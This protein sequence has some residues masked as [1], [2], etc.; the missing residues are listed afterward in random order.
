[1]KQ[2]KLILLL[3]GIFVMVFFA[4]SCTTEES[5]ES[6]SVSKDSEWKQAL[7]KERREKDENFKK[8]PDSP[9]ARC[10]RL[11]VL[12]D[13]G[14]AFVLEKENDVALTKEKEPGVKFSIVFEGEQ[15]LWF[16]HAQGVTGTAGDKPVEPRTPL[17]SRVTFKLDRC[18]L[19]TYVMKDRLLFMVYD[20]LRPEFKEFSHLYYFPPDSKYNVPAV[21]EIFPTIEEFKVLTSQNEEKT[22]HRYARI[23][24]NVDGKPYQLTAFKFSMEKNDPNSKI[25]FIPFSDGT[26]GNETYEVGRF[27]EIHEPGK[28]EFFLDFNRC[29]N[30]LCNYSPGF[31]CPIPP[32]ENH[33]DVAIKAG[34]KTYPH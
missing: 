1:M 29:F 19:K 13:Q 5:D 34:E 30:P 28:K 10:K 22:Y 32:L 26:S 4:Q 7:L 20:P 14:E 11:V 23:K 27:L 2:T 9:M 8:F 6:I 15:W 33:L 3:V 24:F 21:M 16:S 17:P 31:N 18:V 25:L 12:S